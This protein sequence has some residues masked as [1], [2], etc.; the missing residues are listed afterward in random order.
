MTTISQSIDTNSRTNVIHNRGPCSPHSIQEFPRTTSKST[1]SSIT[2]SILKSHRRRLNTTMT[3]QSTISNSTLTHRLT[4]RH[5]HRTIRTNLNNHMI[6]LPR[7]TD[8]TISQQSIS[9]PPITTI[10]RQSSR[11]PTRIR[12]TIRIRHR[13]HVPLHTLRPTRHHIT[14][15]TNTISRSQ[16]Q[17]RHN[18]STFSRIPTQNRINSVSNF[19]TRP[20]T[21]INRKLFRIN[22]PL[23]PHT[24]INHS[25]TTT[26]LNRI[27][28][29]RNTRSTSTTNSSNSPVLRSTSP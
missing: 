17:S 18:F 8:L 11:I 13:C 15:S 2:T 22:S 4:Y 19:R 20:S 29:G 16:S 9:S 10:T 1:T 6:N 23:N 26:H 25:R 3:K 14:N 5:R 27:A 21:R 28:T 7:L 12:S 24:R